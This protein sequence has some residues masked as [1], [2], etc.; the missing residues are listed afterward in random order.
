[1]TPSRQWTGV[2]SQVVPPAPWDATVAGDP[3]STHCAHTFFLYASDRV[4]NGWG[5]IHGAASY[6]KSLTLML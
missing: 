3:S 5:Y 2:T 1:V 6:H 4:I